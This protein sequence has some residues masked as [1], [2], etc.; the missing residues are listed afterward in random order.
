MTSISKGGKR[1][2]RAHPPQKE[3]SVHPARFLTKSLFQSFSKNEFSSLFEQLEK[4]ADPAEASALLTQVREKLDSLSPEKATKYIEN[5]FASN[6]DA[7]LASS[8]KVSKNGQLETA[9]TLRTALLD[10][11]AS[12]NPEAT[13]TLSRD[14]L[15]EPTS[16][17]EWALALRNLARVEPDA[18][19]FLI[20]KTEELIRN[21]S[22]QT[23]P[24]IGYL[25]AFDT[26]AY[27]GAT[28]STPLLS[29]LVQRKDRQDLAHASFLTL[30]RLTLT[31]TETMLSLIANDLALQQSRPEMASQQLARADFRHEAQR[32]IIR[33]WLLSPERTSTQLHSFA[34]TFP[35]GNMMISNN[36]LTTTQPFSGS[37]LRDRDLRS[38][39]TIDT[40]LHLPEFEP[41]KEH[42]ETMSRRLTAFVNQAESSPQ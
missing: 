17:D 8:F 3:H 39:E 32:Q 42:L 35:S 12:I 41:I 27:V 13:A 16:A 1:N 15:A 14:L 29:E 36:L 38:L 10:H 21:P 6:Q 30:D 7:Q 24:S 28:E 5:Y 18:R 9:P 4:T 19:D 34:G 2:T 33:E 40:W 20:K 25:N 26:L 23:Q 31:N 22:W 37:E 11:L